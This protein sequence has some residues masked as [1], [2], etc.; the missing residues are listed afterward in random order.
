MTSQDRNEARWFDEDCRHQP[1]ER[2]D[3]GKQTA[4]HGAAGSPIVRRSVAVRGLRGST[5]LIRALLSRCSRRNRGIV[6]KEEIARYLPEDPVVLEA[7]AHIGVD[8]REM[9]ALWP[10]GAIHAFEPIPAIFERLVANTRRLPNVRCYPLALGDRNGRA[11]M[12]VSGG[13]SDGASSL[14]AP[15]EHLTE[16][17]DVTFEGT[18]EVQTV[19]IDDWA[20][21]HGI[22]R[23]DLLWLDMQGY[24]LAAMRA[25]ERVLSSVRAIYTEVSLREV[26]EAA[27][28]YAEVRTWLESR[29]FRA[30][31]EALPWRDMGNVL[32]VR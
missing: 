7:G 12:Y 4:S 1:A 5:A 10:R 14:L 25:G 16:H 15:K 31:C 30:A 29:G 27:P 2:V 6:R 19:T 20:R 18:I 22:E 9:S 17:P 28:L 24:E 8:T 21:D 11:R 32:F 26:Y 23:V 13:G 3:A